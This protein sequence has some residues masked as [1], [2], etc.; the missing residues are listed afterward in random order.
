[1]AE[2]INAARHKTMTTSSMENIN[3]LRY[4][5]TSFLLRS[6]SSIRLSVEDTVAVIEGES[7]HRYIPEGQTVN[8]QTG[9]LCAASKL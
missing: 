5:L 3:I 2:C 7:R 9:E 1:M 4:F 8:M 6:S